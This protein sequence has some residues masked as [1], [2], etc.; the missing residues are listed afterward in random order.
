MIVENPPGRVVARD[1]AAATITALKNTSHQKVLEFT[2]RN[3][4]R[5]FIAFF[6]NAWDS[7]FDN[8]VTSRV[9]V[10]NCTIQEFQDSTVQFAPPESSDRE[11]SPWKE[12]PQGST[13]RYEVDVDN[14]VA[15]P[16]TGLVTG[17]FVIKYLPQENV[18]LDLI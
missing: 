4:M 14:A 16:A 17:R 3:G 7:G 9:M 18:G 11:I 10:D 13:V 12:I 5:P 8:H 6:G 15:T 1:T 2:V